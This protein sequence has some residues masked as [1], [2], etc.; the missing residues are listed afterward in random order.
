MGDWQQFGY[1]L[2]KGRGTS[3]EERKGELGVRVGRC[4]E[5]KMDRRVVLEM[6][7]DC[8][9]AISCKLILFMIKF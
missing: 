7:R 8:W 6:S 5:G 9:E 2:G 3:R 4:R 1:F